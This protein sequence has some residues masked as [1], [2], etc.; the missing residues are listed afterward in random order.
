MLILYDIL[1]ASP[2]LSSS[3]QPT[4]WLWETF[5]PNCSLI[6]LAMDF[7]GSISLVAISEQLLSCENMH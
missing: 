6:Y 5:F 7:P 4:V 3:V 2:V 1:D